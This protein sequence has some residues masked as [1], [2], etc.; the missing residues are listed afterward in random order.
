[1][2]GERE[3]IV[4]LANIPSDEVLGMRS[5][6]LQIGGD[7]QFTML[8]YNQFEYDST[9]LNEITR[10]ELIWPYTFDYKL[11]VKHCQI[12]PCPA[13]SYPGLWEV[14]IQGV[15]DNHGEPCSSF[16]K[17]Y[18][19][20]KTEQDAFDVLNIEF[21]KRY[22]ESRAPFVINLHAVWFQVCEVINS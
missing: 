9:L 6:Y 4:K 22:K 1:M 12:D 17:C 20:P 13:N 5:P 2:V 18:N 14:P 7:N 10:T 21:E 3:N 19:Q 15:Y 8:Y 16:D 11:T